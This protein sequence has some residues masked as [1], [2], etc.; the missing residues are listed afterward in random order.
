MSARIALAP[1]VL[2]AAV[3]GGA[4]DGHGPAVRRALR[5]WVEDGAEI[6]VAGWAWPTLL[7][8]LRSRGWPAARIAEALHVLDGLDIRTVELDLPALLLAADAM[9][10]HDLAAPA[11]A[12][13]VL[14]DLEH[15]QLASLDPRV[16]GA[17]ARGITVG[18]AVESAPG[19]GRRPDRDR[20]SRTSLPDYR[21]LGALL[22]ELRRT[23]EARR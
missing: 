18:T 6:L 2:V 1:D 8:A 22:G 14:A 12:T 5:T 15:A 23:A 17:A 13:L 9:E 16:T 3:A 19:S 4:A 21:G 11:A 7:D 10:R 20:A